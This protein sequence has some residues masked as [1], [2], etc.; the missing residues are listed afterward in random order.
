MLTNITYEKCIQ[1]LPI[2]SMNI[3][4]ELYI[5][6]GMEIRQLFGRILITL[7]NSKELFFPS[8]NRITA[9]VSSASLTLVVLNAR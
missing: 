5:L 9:S 7:K 6:T 4:K 2:V 3:N 8:R 1:N